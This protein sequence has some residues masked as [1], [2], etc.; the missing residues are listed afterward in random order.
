MQKKLALE[1]LYDDFQR[2]TGFRAVFGVEQ[3]FYLNVTEG[4][5]PSTTNACPTSITNTLAPFPFFS[6]IEEEKGEGQFEVQIAPTDSPVLMGEMVELLREKITSSAASIKIATTNIFAAKPYPSQP[7]SGMHIH[8]NL[9]D[10]SGQNVFSRN[11]EDE[12]EELNQAIAGLLELM[13]ASMKY[14]APYEEAYV[15]YIEHGMD[16]P[17]TIS[18][19]ANNRTASLRLPSVPLMP[20]TRR[21]EHRVPCAD[22]DPYLCIAAILIGAEFGIINKLENKHPKIWGNAFLPQYGLPKLPH[23]FS[24]VK[25]ITHEY[26]D[27]GF[28]G[29]FNTE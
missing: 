3:E 21:I 4:E 1:K 20:H 2:K 17:S 6:A 7:G 5:T 16:G 11:G 10:E 9:L 27:K 23:S 28:S 19:G 12:S 22:A 15:R 29:F 13:P 26:L 8:I 18:W 25:A 24:T 14:F